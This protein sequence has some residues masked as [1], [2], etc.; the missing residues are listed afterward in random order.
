MLVKGRRDPVG[1]AVGPPLT[2][3]VVITF[4]LQA[5]VGRPLAEVTPS[6]RDTPVLPT[7]VAADAVL[8]K[9]AIPA[10]PPSLVPEPMEADACARL[11]PPFDAET[12]VAAARPAAHVALAVEETA[13]QQARRLSPRRRLRQL[14]LGLPIALL[15]KEVVVVRPPLRLAVIEV[16]LG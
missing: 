15:V 11:V 6:T 1:P 2:N 4:L 16:I 5:D 8:L 14:R 7:C 3:S 9:A 10:R 12:A 13:E